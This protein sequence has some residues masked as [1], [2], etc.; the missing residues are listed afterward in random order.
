MKTNIARASKVHPSLAKLG[1]KVE[2]ATAQFEKEFRLTADEAAQIILDGV[3]RN[4]RR[5]LVGADARMLDL[6][7]RWLPGS[8]HALVIAGAKRRL[9]T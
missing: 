2:D 1:V 3:R 7:Q 8:Y 5:V 4:K 6:M 9:K